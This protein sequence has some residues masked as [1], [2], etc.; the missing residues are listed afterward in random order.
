MVSIAA[1]SDLH[2]N[3][4]EIAPCDIL[5][6]AGDICPD[7][8][9]LTQAQWLSSTFR[10]WLEKVPAQHIVGVAGNHDKVF[11]SQ[12]TLL[13]KD[14]PWHYLEDSSIELLGLHIHGT[15]WQLPWWGVFTMSDKAL[16]QHYTSIPASTDI[17]ISHGAP[18]GICDQITTREDL[19]FHT[20]SLALRNR[21][22]EV[23]PMLVVFGHIH[24]GYGTY[25]LGNTLFANVSLV[26]DDIDVVH[27]PFY[28][29]INARQKSSAALL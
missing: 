21:V 5:L 26:D 18:F 10:R 9:P 28:V 22:M 15:P 29:E 27:S 24:T 8:A 25:Q 17:L 3:L 2:G 23:E 12:S 6:I 19:P 14:L 11:A 20:G 16:I 13:P 1:I 4:V 7:A